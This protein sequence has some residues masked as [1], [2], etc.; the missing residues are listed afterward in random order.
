MNFTMLAPAT[1]LDDVYKTLSP[2][3]LLTKEQIEAFYRGQVNK[4]RGDDKVDRFAL[5]LNRA[6][7]GAYYKAFLMGHPGVGKSTELTRLTQQIEDKF[8]AIRFS[9][10]SAL[11]P[12]NFK[13]FDVLLLMMA[14][15][16]EKTAKP[17]SQGGAGV[18]PSDERLQ[19]IWNWFAA[20]KRILVES[21]YVGAEATAGSGVTGDSWWAKIL[22]L[23]GNVKGEMKYAADR[24]KEIV[25]YRLSRLS[26]LIELA[27]RLLDDCNQLLRGI[28]QKE[29]LFIG[30]DFDRPGIP[31]TQVEDLFLT[32]ANIF[33]DLRTHLIFTIPVTL[34][35]S[36]QAAQLPFASD[37]LVSL[38]DTPVFQPDHS[39]HDD[40]RGALHAVLNA[41][42]ADNLFEDDQMQR[43]IVAS[44]GNLRDLF[45]LIT[46]ATDNALLRKPP[47]QKIAHADATSAINSLRIEYT[48]RLGHSPHDRDNIPYEEKAKRLVAIYRSDPDAVIP[49]AVLY[50]LLRSRAVQEFNGKGWFGVHPLVVDILKTQ[51]RLSP[52]EEGGT[53]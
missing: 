33:K 15:I 19:E 26:T 44:G 43:L 30:E 46:Q 21:T 50:S 53:G 35:Y 9:A 4:V 8:C 17:R 10:T 28:T 49:D 32:Y 27:N 41:R 36:Q 16:A 52:Q 18:V 38:P 48:R 29:W 34:G 42:L 25:E 2:D 5:A 22:G 31:I 11:D 6:S 51:G 37:R 3:P 20:E 14:E 12:V 39:P 1:S 13:P 7:G 45:A 24:K 23:F 40:G 47:G